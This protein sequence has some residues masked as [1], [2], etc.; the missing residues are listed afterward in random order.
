[1]KFCLLH[2]A[3]V[4]LAVFLYTAACLSKQV[5]WAVFLNT[6]ACSQQA[7]VS[8]SRFLTRAVDGELCCWPRPCRYIAYYIAYYIHTL[9]SCALRSSSEEQS[10]EVRLS[11][12]DSV[13]PIHIAYYI[14]QF[15]IHNLLSLSNSMAKFVAKSI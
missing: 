2:F 15:T 7:F 4:F 11:S 10:T 6:A 5:L 14:I 12:L 9:S 13:L 1:M 3:S 8:A